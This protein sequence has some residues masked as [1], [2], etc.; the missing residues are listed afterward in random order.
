MSPSR[1]AAASIDCP[2]FPVT[3]IVLFAFLSDR[4]GSIFAGRLPSPL[5]GSGTEGI[6]LVVGL[7]ALTRSGGRSLASEPSVRVTGC[8]VPFSSGSGVVPVANHAGG[9][10]VE[11]SALPNQTEVTA[12]FFASG[13][14]RQV[15]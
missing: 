10:L 8:W 5:G 13:A 1:K 2:L 9:Y 4:P 6:L 7:A 15:V 14:A 11:Q 12:K 3:L